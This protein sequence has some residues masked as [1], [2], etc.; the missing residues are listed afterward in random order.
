MKQFII[1]MAILPFLFLFL[2]QYTLD[3]QNSHHIA[4]FQEHVYTAKEKAKQEG[5]FTGE[6]KEELVQK[7]AGDFDL[8]EGDIQVTLEEMP[9]YRT[10]VFDE[11][12]LIHYKVSVPIDK[13]MAGNKFLGI[14]DNENS[15]MYTIESWTASEFIGD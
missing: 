1:L 5:R 2:L 14:P 9:Q 7:I 10:N 3:Q 8:D 6:I 4:R 11:R 12:E 15:Y 13:I